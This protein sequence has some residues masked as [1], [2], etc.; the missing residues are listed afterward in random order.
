MSAAAI[1]LSPLGASS[2]MAQDQQ[3]KSTY[4]RL[5]P[6]AAGLLYEPVTLGSKSQIAILVMHSSADYMGFSACTELSG[7]GYRVLC[8]NS[9]VLKGRL[10]RNLGVD[11]LVTDAGLGVKYLRKYPGVRK[12]LIWGHS[13]GGTVMSAYQNIAEN[14]LKACQGPEKIIRC[15]DSLAGLPPADGVLLIDSNWGLAAMMLFSLDP[16]VVNE[17]DGI[18]LNPALDMFNPANGFD[19]EGTP[20]MSMGPPPGS[21]KDGQMPAPGPNMPNLPKD[22]K[23]RTG[24]TYSSE[25][26]HRFLSAEG[27]RNNQ[28]IKTALDRWEAINTGKGHYTDDEPFNVTGGSLAVMNNKLYTQ[29]LRLMSHTR[30]PWPLLRADG[31]STAQTIYSVRVPENPSSVT[32]SLL[33]GTLLSTVH[34]FLNTYA[35]RVTGDYG[36]DEDSVHG[37]DWSSSYSNPPGNV[38]GIT[39]PMLVMGMTGSFEYLASETIYENAK[40]ADKT[41][42]FVEG[43]SHTYNTCKRCEKTP[44]QF[45]DTQKT[46][47]DY[48]DKWL[49]QKG[50]FLDGAQ[51]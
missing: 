28:L 34:E 47:Y 29:D 38:K 13:G 21:G 16:A 43:A 5:G 46:I 33:G 4:V 39:V 48:V 20:P 24:S 26:I 7:R 12:V 23:P 22:S 9:L 3:I 32:G 30:N 40:S 36:Y 50:R 8:A 49:S 42:V 2:S 19:T 11:G 15:S 6:G 14:G 44:G 41:L 37:I 51:P 18:K 25:F 17:G 45:G 31:S 27:K 1:A 35:V 10:A